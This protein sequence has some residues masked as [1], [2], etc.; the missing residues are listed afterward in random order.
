MA[1]VRDVEPAVKQL[2]LRAEGYRLLALALRA[3]D[4]GELREELEAVP[5]EL[6][7]L[8]ELAARLDDDVRFE[9]TRLFAQST[10]VSPYEGSY[11]RTDK[12]A[13][14]GQ[15]AAFYELFGARVG[16]EHEPPDHIGCQLEFAALLT[17]KH[18]LALGEGDEEHAAVAARARRVLLEEHLGRWAGPFAGRLAERTQHV[19]FATLAD[20]LASFVE[21]DLQAEGWRAEPLVAGRALPLVE[22]EELSCPMAES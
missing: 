5:P 4:V 14:L 12:G 10:P 11:V 21:G 19:F 18:A 20:V 9:H 1:S 13:L 16:V 6:A 7:P 2:L 17:L 8:G 22:G 3:P 15:L